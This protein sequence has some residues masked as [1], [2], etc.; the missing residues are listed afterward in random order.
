MLKYPFCSSVLRPPNSKSLIMG[1]EYLLTDQKGAC[2]T[3]QS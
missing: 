1:A 2:F 3:E